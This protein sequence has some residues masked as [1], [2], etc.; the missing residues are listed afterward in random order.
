M[1]YMALLIPAFPTRKEYHLFGF[2][3]VAEKKEK[4][5]SRLADQ[6]QT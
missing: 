3:L 1:E 4:A 5:F 6:E 2:L